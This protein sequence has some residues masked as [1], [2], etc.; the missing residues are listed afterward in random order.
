MRFY[1]EVKKLLVSDHGLDWCFNKNIDFFSDLS[2]TSQFCSIS[3]SGRT[4]NL[5]WKRRHLTS[6]FPT[7]HR[8]FLLLKCIWINKESNQWFLEQ[9]KMSLE[10]L[11][12]RKMKGNYADSSGFTDC[13]SNVPWYR[14][15]VYFLVI[16]LPGGRSLEIK[17]NGTVLIQWKRHYV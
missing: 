4:G 6:L 2:P 13:M 5:L 16:I 1:P 17:M 9:L 15:Q 8:C 10:N 7:E 14:T 3:E 11:V 12:Y